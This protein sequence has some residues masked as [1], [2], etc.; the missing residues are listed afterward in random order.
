MICST[1]YPIPG[2]QV[3]GASSQAPRDT[4][5]YLSFAAGIVS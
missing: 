2:E 5:K 1:L 3:A 4:S